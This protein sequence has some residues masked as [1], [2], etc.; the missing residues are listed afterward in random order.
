MV[1]LY[2]VSASLGSTYYFAEGNVGPN[3]DEYITVL[4]RN[5]APVTVHI[6]F[7]DQRGAGYASDLL[8]GPNS[9]GTFKANWIVPPGTQVTAT[10]TAPGGV[11]ILVERPE[12]FS[13]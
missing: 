4:N 8:V 12:Y 1:A 13:Y 9:R 2:T 3:F 6:V 10:V 11:P 5:A 7:T